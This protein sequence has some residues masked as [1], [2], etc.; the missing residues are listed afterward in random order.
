MSE[1]YH[2]H[3]DISTELLVP[4]LIHVRNFA[5]DRRETKLSIIEHIEQTTNVE[6]TLKPP[7]GAIEHLFL[8]GKALVVFDGLDEV[9]EAHER[10]EIAAIIESFC[11]RFPAAPV[12]VTSR[13]VGYAEASLNPSVFEVFQ[14]EDFN[15]NQVREYVSK[16]FVLAGY[17][18][19]EADKIVE[20]FVEESSA[21]NDL[22]AN[23]LMLALMCNL[24][25]KRHYIPKNRPEL[26]SKCT[27]ILLSRDTVKGIKN[28]LPFQHHIVHV[29]RFLAHWIFT[30]ERLNTG[31]RKSELV[32][33]STEFL[34]EE[35][36]E[37]RAEAE[38]AAKEFVQHCTARLWVFTDMGPEIYKFAHNTFLEFYSAE[39]LVSVNGTSKELADILLPRI[40][41]QEWDVVAQ[42]AVQIQ[43]ERLRGAG[44]EFLEQ[45]MQSASG[46]TYKVRAHLLN[47]ALRSLE[48]MVPRPQVMRSIIESCVQ[49]LIENAVACHTSM[50]SETD[51]EY[52]LM[53]I[54]D[55]VPL[56]DHENRATVSRIL[57]EILEKTYSELSIIERRVLFEYLLHMRTA[58]TR[59]RRCST[60]DAQYWSDFSKGIMWRHTSKLKQ[61]SECDPILAGD[62]IWE[63]Y[64][65]LSSV[66]QWH[67]REFLISDYSFISLPKV[68]RSSFAQ[69][70]FHSIF[71]WGNNDHYVWSR[72]LYD[73]TSQ[74]GKTVCESFK[75]FLEP[76]DNTLS[77]QLSIRRAGV[78][79]D[80]PAV[81]ARYHNFCNNP[82]ALFG[83]FVLLA[84]KI[85]M[86]PDVA[87][88]D[89]EVFR[90]LGVSIYPALSLRGGEFPPDF[91]PEYYFQSLK[92]NEEQTQFATQWLKGKLNLFE[93]AK[94]D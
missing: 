46:E 39:Y 52:L 88:E 18:Q 20:E 54:V 58:L 2:Q 80:Q 28:P 11:N 74:F 59:E 42:I 41:K 34:L 81:V 10:Q 56:L 36:F 4:I 40:R 68:Y 79:S 57:E 69:W 51:R 66:V 47:F 45:L 67:G 24:Y 91:V 76:V 63:G 43:N 89:V 7:N 44:S 6:L 17:N 85:E 35:K 14:L 21:V 73:M 65:A 71:W 86:Y 70:L 64:I 27:E 3:S 1:I 92:F 12:L 78:A 38:A 13:V 16:W 77:T 37:T 9:L 15:D 32:E 5:N 26:Y 25:R 55:Y 29:I 94:A 84:I 83:L 82:D 30:T 62:I 75:P 90:S 49:L 19:T 87:K 53:Q 48:F 60:E 61:L 33:K 72:A 31:V 50:S 93:I 22:R 23:P 8:T